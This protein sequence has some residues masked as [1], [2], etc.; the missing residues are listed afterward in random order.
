M[1]DVFFKSYHPVIHQKR[2]SLVLIFNLWTLAQAIKFLNS[3]NSIYSFKP[4]SLCPN[5]HLHLIYPLIR[6]GLEASLDQVCNQA[7]MIQTLPKATTDPRVKF[8]SSDKCF[9]SINNAKFK[10]FGLVGLV[11]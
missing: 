1:R 2:L 4:W 7:N 5:I 10:R 11:L 3:S 8:F 9:N 6:C